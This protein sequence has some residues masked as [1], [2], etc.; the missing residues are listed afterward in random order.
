MTRRPSFLVIEDSEPDVFLLRLS[1]DS[2]FT[3]YELIQAMDGDAAIEEI[4]RLEAGAEVPDLI[5]IDLNL[6]RLS[7]LDLLSMIRNSPTLRFAPA[8]VLTS[9]EN[10]KDKQ[11]AADLGV[12]AFIKKPSSLDEFMTVGAIL[13]RHMENYVLENQSSSD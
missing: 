1:L 5:V 11:R 2:E 10:P 13:K 4:R 12:L 6:P 8:V 7:G 9:S 3:E